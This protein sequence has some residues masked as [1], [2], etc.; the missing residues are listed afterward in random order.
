MQT[1]YWEEFLRTNCR[2]NHSRTFII[3]ST[4][5]TQKVL[6]EY[7]KRVKET[8]NKI[9]NPRCIINTYFDIAD[10]G[11][12]PSDTVFSG[13]IDKYGNTFYYNVY[14]LSD[15]YQKRETLSS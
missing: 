15:F 13:Q 2:P 5:H 4:P 14:P 10:N 1:L 11:K 3:G 6:D 9:V 12:M 8:S 7:I